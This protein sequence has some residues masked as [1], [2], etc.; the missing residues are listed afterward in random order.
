MVRFIGR[1]LLQQ[2]TLGRRPLWSRADKTWTPVESRCIVADDGHTESCHPLS[3]DN[4]S[5]KSEMLKD[6]FGSL[7]EN[8]KFVFFFFFFVFVWS[9]RLFLRYVLVDS[10]LFFSSFFIFSS[11][12]TFLFPPSVT[13]QVLDKRWH[14][15]V[16]DCRRSRSGIGQVLE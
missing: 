1:T 12:A 6:V 5:D 16:P 7:R 11:F 13:R 4:F 14:I 9:A 10:H 15:F 8:Q 2:K 3:H